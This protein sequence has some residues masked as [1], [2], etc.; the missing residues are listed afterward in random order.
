MSSTNISGTNYLNLYFQVHQPI[1]LRPFKFFDVGSGKAYFHDE[2]NVQ[3]IKKVAKDCYLPTNKLL[4]KMLKKFPNLRV[5]FSISGTIIDQFEDHTP[6]VI[7]SFKKLSDTG[8]VEFLAETYYHSLAFLIS[9]EEFAYQVGKH[10]DKIYDLFDFMPSVFRNTELIYS[11]DI[12]RTVKQL[13]F[14]GIFIDGVSRIIEGRGFHNLYQHPDKR[15]PRI[16]VRNFKLSD[17]I[18]FRFSDPNWKEW[19]LSA[20]KYVRWLEAIPGDQGIINIALDFETFGEHQKSNT[21]IFLFLKDFL[22]KVGMSK[23]LRMITPSEAIN[24]LLPKGILNVPQF[25]SWAD[26]ERDLSAWLGNDMQLEAFTALKKI[27]NKLKKINNPILINSW[28]YLQTSDHLYYMSTKTHEDGNVHAY[29]SPYSSPYEAFINFMN[30]IS[31]LTF[32]I[33]LYSYMQPI[34]HKTKG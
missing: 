25:I 2:L 11:N 17:D 20:N 9:K 16:F 23:R 10:R 8:S 18:A 28:R 27:R 34:S 22:T 1:R 7:D 29:F 30:I 24:L 21:G 14:N 33:D 5:T 19:P 15:G 32:Q 6:E 13:G 26:K 31:D 4:L 12:G 3:I